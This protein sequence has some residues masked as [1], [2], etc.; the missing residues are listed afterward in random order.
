MSVPSSSELVVVARVRWTGSVPAPARAYDEILVPFDTDEPSRAAVPV[1]ARLAELTGARL[2]LV[3]VGVDGDLDPAE[4]LAVV[5]SSFPAT[6][7][8]ELVADGEPAEVV[9]HE[10]AGASG[11][12]LVCMG[13]HARGRVRGAL[14][15]SVA[16]HVIADVASGVVLVGPEV[17]A[18][19]LFERPVLMAHD[20]G[21]GSDSIAAAALVMAAALDV[22]VDTVV[23]RAAPTGR[24]SAGPYADV[25]DALEPVAQLAGRAG[26]PFGHRIVFGDDVVDTIL[27]EVGRIHPS[28]VAMA[29][30]HRRPLERL[31]E[32]TT[33]MDVV[34]AARVPVLVALSDD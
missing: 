16:E 31:R 19:H 3:A 30:H 33:T 20:G 4:L 6:S 8:L 17:D 21:V 7:E 14:V 5:G 25:E 12:L 13:T 18:A 22:A 27:A 1:A 24:S 28:L 9:A 29:M 11:R 26:V 15:E 32:G 34:R 2:H 23:V 10:V